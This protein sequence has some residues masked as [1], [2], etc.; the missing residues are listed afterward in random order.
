MGRA[1]ARPTSCL[2]PSG[3]HRRHS[4]Q[5]A[6]AQRSGSSGGLGGRRRRFV[7]GIE[8][9]KPPGLMK[10]RKGRKAASERNRPCQSRPAAPRTARR[11]GAAPTAASRSRTE[12]W[13]EESRGSRTTSPRPEA[14]A[15]RP[16]QRP[17]GPTIWTAVCPASSGS[18]L[19]RYQHALEQT[20]HR[21][22]VGA[23][24]VPLA[25]SARRAFHTA[26]QGQQARRADDSAWG[27]PR[28][29]PSLPGHLLCRW[30]VP[31][32]TY[33]SVI[34]EGSMCTGWYL[35]ETITDYMSTA[36]PPRCRRIPAS[37]QRAS[38]ERREQPVR[39]CQIPLGEH[40]LP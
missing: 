33:H 18:V 24:G 11:A 35:P 1:K 21:G 30:P 32:L 23:G 17:G 29:H 22:W 8:H 4:F 7:L 6:I 26:R 13:S 40:W 36:Y 16:R 12:R 20:I 34:G 9:V 19:G 14:R 31:R 15:P 39:G 37:A 27:A 3:E 5:R 25:C 2:T 28:A 38:R 10:R